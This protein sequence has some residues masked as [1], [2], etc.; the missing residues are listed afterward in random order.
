LSVDW[1][2]L[3]LFDCV[4]E[5]GSFTEAAR[6]L[7][8]SQPAL[9]RQIASLEETLGAKLF[10]RHA[11]GLAL[12]HEGEQLFESTRDVSDRIE[13]T[14]MAIEASR[15]KP[16]GELRIAATVAFGSTWLAGQ[17][18][19]FLALYPELRVELVLSDSE[20]DLSRREADCALRFHAPYQTDLIR[21]ALPAIRYRICASPEYLARAGEPRTIDDLDHHRLVAYGP[22]APETMRD[23]NWLLDTGDRAHPRIPV[24]TV[25]N[26]FG[27]LRA[28]EAGVGIALLP[29]YLV[30][31]SGKLKVILDSAQTPQ[32]RPWFC[33]PA[34]L[35]R[36][37][38]VSAIRDFLTERMVPD[39]IG[40]VSR[41]VSPET[42]PRT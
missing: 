9:S 22:N 31:F 41:D 21:R 39:A 1:D 19:D 8:L 7:H 4:A 18:A 10:H 11:R 13:R 37:L 42:S 25:N 27:V 36:S 34:E 32:F 29:S 35:R 28:A 20:S 12:T 14:R 23:V 38:R 24:L 15:D 17:M 6:R 26:S 33:Y 3:R 16:T 40:G 2:K 30:N 5:A